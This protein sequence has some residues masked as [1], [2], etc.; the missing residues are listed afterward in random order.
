MAA[1][2][3]AEHLSAPSLEYATLKD[4]LKG[5]VHPTCGEAVIVNHVDIPRTLADLDAVEIAERSAKRGNAKDP[6]RSELSSMARTRT[7]VRRWCVHHGASRKA[8]LT[9]REGELPADVDALWESVRYF[10]RRLDRLQLAQPLVVPEA[11]SKTGR[12]HLHAAFPQY[13][14]Q[15][16]LESVWGHGFVSID[17][18]K[19]KGQTERQII[20]RQAAYLAGYVAK[21]GSGS[22]F[23]LVGFNRRRYSIPKGSSPPPPVLI[24][25]E[26]LG[27][28]RT[29]AEALCGHPLGVAWTSDS[30]QDWE[31]PRT[32]VLQG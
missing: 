1:R 5:Y 19:V 18:R 21:L 24:S 2:D 31:G 3:V 17:R 7:K 15:P 22:A 9:Y 11:G 23:D 4:R 28:L 32:A 12:L 25:G 16:V 29:Q 8:T 27:D 13:V 20:R 30:H 6:T 26:T 10:R 14:P